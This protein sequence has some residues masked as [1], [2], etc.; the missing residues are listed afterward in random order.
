MAEISGN[1][2]PIYEF[3][4]GYCRANDNSRLAECTF[5]RE[6]DGRLK[7]DS[8]DCDYGQCAY[9]DECTVAKAALEME[10]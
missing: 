10:K 1:P 5:F 3:V 2:N 9:S 6:P 4:S 7:L 8:M